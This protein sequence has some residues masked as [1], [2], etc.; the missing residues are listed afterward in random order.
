MNSFS[1][2]VLL[3]LFG[4]WMF[5]PAEIAGMAGLRT[6]EVTPSQSSPATSPSSA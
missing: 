6:T 4:S 1:T 3:W 5:D 2:L